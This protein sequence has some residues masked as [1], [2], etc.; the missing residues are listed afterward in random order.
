M[1]YS[2]C[3]GVSEKDF[4]DLLELE[5]TM[6]DYIFVRHESLIKKDSLL[7][8]MSDFYGDAVILYS[9]LEA[10]VIELDELIL[11]SSDEKLSILLGLIK[12]ICLL[13]IFQ[14]ENMYGFG[15]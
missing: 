15:E 13:G 14:G 1:G 11:C 3:L 6:Y 2:I 5:E 4:D 8:R 12:N 10:L 7:Y 9:E